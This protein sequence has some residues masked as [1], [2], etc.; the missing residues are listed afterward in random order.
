MF[1]RPQLQALI[2]L[3][4]ADAD[5]L[6][7][8]VVSCRDAVERQGVLEA[9]QQAWYGTVCAPPG[10]EGWASCST[11]VMF[12]NKSKASGEA[13]VDLIT[14]MSSAQHVALADG[15]KHRFWVVDVH[16]LCRHAQVRLK[17]QMERKAATCQF[18]L[19]A[20]SPDG[21]IADLR[22][23]CTAVNGNPCPQAVLAWLRSQFPDTSCDRLQQAADDPRALGCPRAAEMLLRAAASGP[24]WQLPPDLLAAFTDDALSGL[25]RVNDPVKAAAAIRKFARTCATFAV[26]YALV[27]DKLVAAADRVGA[28]ATA[29]AL[30]AA[31]VDALLSAESAATGLCGMSDMLGGPKH[32]VVALETLLWHYF[33]RCHSNG[34]AGGSTATL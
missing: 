28:D 4:A 17:V 10:P 3:P 25:R 2:A 34:P 6:P 7:P 33:V 27:V 31:A 30:D 15:Q 13:L 26:P 11:H 19:F 32:V 29:L 12:R 8:L 1:A 21:V 22:G 24:G 9:L 14:G 5:G 18:V 23:R 20:S 16:T